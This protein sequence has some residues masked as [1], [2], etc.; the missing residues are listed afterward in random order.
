MPPRPIAA[1][2][3]ASEFMQI[4]LPMRTTIFPAIVD[5]KNRERI[6]NF[7]KFIEEVG[8][9]PQCPEN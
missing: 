9:V 8:L 3:I 4:G 1:G 5:F 2:G 7:Q 6:I